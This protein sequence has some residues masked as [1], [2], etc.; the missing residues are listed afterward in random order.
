MASLGLL[1]IATK[2]S[3]HAAGEPLGTLTLALGEARIL[4]ATAA[5]G[6]HLREHANWSLVVLEDDSIVLLVLLTM[7]A[8][9]IERL[10]ELLGLL[11]LDVGR[12]V[13]RGD[14]LMSA[15]VARIPVMP[16]HVLIANVVI[17]VVRALLLDR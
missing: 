15:I 8:E 5:A 6:A 4:A 10:D 1:E 12:W 3:I 17:L 9:W 7:V 14:V 16:I 2:T 13:E 11:A